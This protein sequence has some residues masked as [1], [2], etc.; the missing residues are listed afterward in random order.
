MMSLTA[1]ENSYFSEICI[2]RCGG[3]CCDPWWG[4]ISYPMVKKKGSADLASFRTQVISSIRERE[5]RI[6]DAYVTR[7]D[8]PRA[9][10]DRP[11]RYNVRVT[12]IKAEGTTLKLTIL[13]MFAFR[14]RFLMDNKSC[15]LHPSAMGG[16]EDIR[17]EHCGYLG[18][19]NAGAGEKGYCRIIHA[20]E[21]PGRVSAGVED[22]IRMEKETSIKH[23]KEGVRTIE[24]AAGR[25]VATVEEYAER[26]LSHL[27]P[28]TSEK[29]AG[30]N[31]PCPCG[32]GKK[33]K[34]CC[35]R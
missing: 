31:D 28:Q 33:F 30:R 34:K 20:A 24:D 9:L 4:I 10:F 26:N 12:G 22:A 23:F 19:L 3:S 27:K 16:G 17:P 13:A 5:K 14:C 25:I 8:A 35:G 15:G 2:E 1:E 7:E 29:K 6:V 18:S 21:S 11:E 32:S